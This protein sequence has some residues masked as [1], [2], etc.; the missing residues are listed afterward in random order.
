MGS[1]SREDDPLLTMTRGAPD[2]S[3]SAVECGDHRYRSGRYRFDITVH[4][5]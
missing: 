1:T 3:G 2:S 5:T 4:A